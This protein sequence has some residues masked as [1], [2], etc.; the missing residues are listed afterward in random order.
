MK[1][2]SFILGDYQTNS[3]VLGSSETAADCLIIDTGLEV[4]KLLDFLEKNE[5]NPLALILTHGHADHIAGVP[6][7]REKFPEIKV[8][9]H[10]LD[11]EMFTKPLHN[12]SMLAGS[13]FKTEPADFL[14]EAGDIIDQAGIKFE[15]IHT[16]GHTPGGICLYCRDEGIAFVG[17]TLFADSIGRTDFPNGD[18]TQLLNSIREKLFTLPDDT[19]VYTGHGPSTTIAHEKAYNPFLR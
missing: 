8:Y 14:I 4:D 16:P 5:L 3:Y 10:K 17:D 15:V 13:F 2:E 1:I 7:L 19:I 18:M 12:L 6:I 11:A 9:I